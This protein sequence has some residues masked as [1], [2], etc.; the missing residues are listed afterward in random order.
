[1][2]LRTLRRLRFESRAT[3]IKDVPEI[4]DVV[5]YLFCALNIFAVLLSILSHTTRKGDTVEMKAILC[6]CNAFTEMNEVAA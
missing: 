6:K 2:C 5:V 3:K 4:E 1:M